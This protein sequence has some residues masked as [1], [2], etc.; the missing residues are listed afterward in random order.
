MSQAT[1]LY[2]DNVTVFSAGTTNF[3]LT[4]KD[5]SWDDSVETAEN[6]ALKDAFTYV[7]PRKRTMKIDFNEASEGAVNLIPGTAYTVAAT[8]GGETVTGT[9]L[10]IS[11]GWKVGDDGQQR[12]WSF[13]YQGEPTWSYA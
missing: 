13:Q 10:L 1:R 4:I 12:A 2:I 8:T 5:A 9:A 3:L 11:R 6:G 7:K